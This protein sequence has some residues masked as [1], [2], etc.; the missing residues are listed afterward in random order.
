[1]D[2]MKKE[3]IDTEVRWMDRQMTRYRADRQTDRSDRQNE[4]R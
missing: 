3:M 4:W 1:M 2:K